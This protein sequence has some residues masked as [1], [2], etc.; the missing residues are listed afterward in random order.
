[1]SFFSFKKEERLKSRK[2]I[3]ALFKRGESVFVFPI[4]LIWKEEDDTTF[5]TPVKVSFT[6]PKRAFPKAVQRNFIKRKMREA[7]RL[8]K[9]VFYAKAKENQKQYA[10]MFIYVAREPLPYKTVE[11]AIVSLLARIR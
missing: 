8:N 3:D 6:V 11:K 2:I 7:Y 5:N 9:H 1:M 4:K 10:M